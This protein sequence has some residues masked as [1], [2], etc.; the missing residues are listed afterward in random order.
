MSVVARKVLSSLPAL[1][2][3]GL[4]LA[5]TP[6]AAQSAPAGGFADARGI[7]VNLEVLTAIPL[8]GPIAGS[9]IDPNTLS[10]ASQS[11][12]PQASEP[13]RDAVLN[14]NA[15]PAATADTVGTFADARCDAPAAVAAA[16]TEGLTALINAAGVP[17]VT[18][19]VIRAQANSDCE[20]PPNAEGSVF[21]NLR[22]NGTPVPLGPLGAPPPNTRIEIPGLATVIINEQNPSADGRGIVVNGVHIIGASP[23]LRGDLIISHA[24]S[25]VVCPNGRGSEIA[26]GLEAPDIT[27]DK[28][29]SP[30][31]ARA[32]DTVT[33]NATV[34]N[35]SDE[36]CDV[37][38]FVDH[39]HPSFEFVSTTGGFGDVVDDPIA[40]RSD[41]GQDVVY[42]PTELVIEPAASVQQT[43]V[44]R[45]RADVA[46]GTYFNNLELFCAVNGDFAS[47]PLAPVT[48]VANVAPPPPPPP[49]VEQPRS[50]PS[51]GN[52]P[53]LALGALLL[54]AGSL[55]VRRAP[56]T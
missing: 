9:P 39:L 34:T 42:R 49:P 8:P 28:D 17:V 41:G 44:V 22:I 53:A 24:V 5:P 7:I 4:A 2:L 33:Y 56:S 14:V 20:T 32:G 37:I 19:D 30:S 29:A 36:P 47:G 1:A 27:F 48:A 31:T 40:A 52:A 16:Q 43:I 26:E 11:C 10:T 25:G 6:V 51:T 21:T 50:L 13:V 3:A 54:L 45:L 55:I 12:P 46:P 38:S 35:T 18:A 23:L 15:P